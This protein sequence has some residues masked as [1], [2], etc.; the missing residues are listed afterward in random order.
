MGHRQPCTPVGVTAR[1]AG[2]TNREGEHET[3]GRRAV[4]NISSRNH[5]G[6]PSSLHAT[7]TANRRA[8]QMRTIRSRTERGTCLSVLA[9]VV[10][11]P[12]V[13]GGHQRPVS[14]LPWPARSVLAGGR[15]RQAA[16]RAGARMA[17]L[18]A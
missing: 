1:Q 2:H 10:P 9:R 18:E 8:L 7:L 13:K 14:V 6:H 17:A 16:M 4:N 11:S 15:T 5:T 3:R 12:S